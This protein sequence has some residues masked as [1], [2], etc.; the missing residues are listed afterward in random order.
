[1]SAPKPPMPLKAAPLI[2]NWI[3]V[4]PNGSIMVLSG[5][6]ELGQGNASAICRMAADEF[7][8]APDTLTIENGH[9]G[10][11]PDE[12]FTAGSMSIS[13]GGQAVRWA[14][15]AFR[16]LALK[17]GSEK[18]GCEVGDLSLANG[19]V[20]KDGVPTDLT[21]GGL[22]GDL[23]LDQP[24]V[25]WAAPQP[26]QRRHS[27]GVSLRLDLKERLTGAPFVHDMERPGM[28]YGKPV[29]PP[30]MTA[31]LEDL[32]LDALK[33]RPGVV[34]V[35][36]D[37]SFIGIVAETEVEAIAAAR[38]ARAHARWVDRAQ[39]PNDP[40]QAIGS[41]AEPAEVVVQSGRIAVGE[42]AQFETTV[43]RPYLHHGSIGPSAAV[44]EWQEGELTVWCH[45]QGVYQLRSALGMVFGLA[46][47]RITVVHRP[48]SGCYGHN[49]A[50]DVALDAALM[51]KSVP[52]RPVKVVWSR[53]DEFQSAPMGPGMVTQCAAT[54]GD[55]GRIS[56]CVSR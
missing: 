15:S 48:G 49:G 20:V 26:R 9:T 28:L 53:R 18:L 24:V 47:D 37:G 29:H 30:S 50:D 31:V 6:V 14:A 5:R 36:R 16:N 25:E 19:V 23:A 41:S 55:E 40:I 13:G 7:G 35:V 11:T 34:A 38:W 33:A 10:L 32:D 2:S 39:A 17:A 22:V 45:S 4:S 54:V 27:V 56:S 43:S 3:R 12:G 42:G 46:Q 44:A 8:C 51:A 1:M 21:L 52:G